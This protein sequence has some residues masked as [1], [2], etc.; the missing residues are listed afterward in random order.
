VL[1]YICSIGR[2]PSPKLATISALSS[3]TDKKHLPSN[4][5][6]DP[7]EP[8]QLRTLFNAPALNAWFTRPTDL[9]AATGLARNAADTARSASTLVADNPNLF[10]A[11]DGGA[12]PPGDAVPS[13]IRLN[14]L[15]RY[16][17][18]ILYWRLAFL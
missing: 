14:R 8:A 18:A 4:S 3:P 15:L 11:T 17:Y 9:A 6:M 1:L 13:G 7:V 16:F 10:A 12:A 2:W 5:P